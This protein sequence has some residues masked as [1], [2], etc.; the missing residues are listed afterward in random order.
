MSLIKKYNINVALPTD[1]TGY[2]YKI[3]NTANNKVYIGQTKDYMKRITQHLEGNGSKPLLYDLVMGSIEKFK[4]EVLEIFYQNED[5]DTI[6]DNYIQTLNSLHPLGY[7]LRMNQT[8]ESNGDTIDLS[9]IEIQAKFCF[10]KNGQKVFSVGE[11][12]QS[13]AYQ[14]LTNIKA[15]TETENI[16]RKKLFKFNYLE[17]KTTSDEGFMEGQIYDLTV[18][19]KFGEDLFLITSASASD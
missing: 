4:F 15:N 19:Y 5:L 17:L 13:R 14:I 12:T 16:T 8:I 10:N 6:E 2:I 18:K 9:S 1:P 3:T 7:N 11:F